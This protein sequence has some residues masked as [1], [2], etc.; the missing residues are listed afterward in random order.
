VAT[1]AGELRQ[2]AHDLQAHESMKQKW[3]LGSD[4]CVVAANDAHAVGFRLSPGQRDDGPERRELI[5][6][7][8][9]P[10]AACAHF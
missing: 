1:R 8:G 2:L 7:L 6:E 5:G 9:C 10:A 3:G 4:L